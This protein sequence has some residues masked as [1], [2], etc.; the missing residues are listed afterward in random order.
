MPSRTC[1]TQ[2]VSMMSC[3]VAPSCTNRPASPA[4]RRERPHERDE[5]V[6][7]RE[8]AGT[9]LLEI[10]GVGA[11]CGADRGRSLGRNQPALGLGLG[12]RGLGVEPGLKQRPGVEHAA[13]RRRPKEVA[14]ERAIERRGHV[15]PPLS[16][17]T[18]AEG[19]QLGVGRRGPPKHPDRLEAHYS[20]ARCWWTKRQ[21]GYSSFRQARGSAG[22]AFGVR[23]S[24]KLKYGA[25]NGSGAITV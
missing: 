18:A 1:R 14:E 17:W 13:H 25:T 3:V 24:R 21:S 11:S 22:W 23:S 5:R 7:G 4:A 9:Q 8:D 15:Q 12:E 10:V 6:L 20:L 2:P 19:D 16:R